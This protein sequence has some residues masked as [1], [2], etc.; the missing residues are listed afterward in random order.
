[1][2]I[3]LARAE[4]LKNLVSVAH[5]FLNDAEFTISKKDGFV[6]KQQDLTHSA[7][8]HAVIGVDQFE[9]FMV[10]GD[11]PIVLRVDVQRMHQLLAKADDDKP[12]FLTMKTSDSAFVSMTC[13]K[14]QKYKTHQLKLS[15]PEEE[16]LEIPPTEYKSVVTIDAQA[17]KDRLL[18]GSLP[19]GDVTFSTL[20]DQFR[21]E[22]TSRSTDEV[23]YA[24]VLARDGT[25]L[26]VDTKRD[27]AILDTLFLRT[28]VKHSE[29]FSAEVN[30]KW[31]GTRVPFL[32]EYLPPQGGFVRFYV[33]PKK[34]VRDLPDARANL[35]DSTLK[36]S[37]HAQELVPPPTQKRF[38]PVPTTAGIKKTKKRKRY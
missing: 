35:V 38:K 8:L 29:P 14:K 24:T 30:L 10:D 25:L 32:M 16:E 6:W 33:A 22:E 37:N 26:E 12:L 13:H 27:D 4:T 3:T 36:A 19:Y 23:R 21:Y 2:H 34:I 17:W 20:N 9:Q 18:N 5:A 7:L 1:M 11:A 15:K 31:S 28:F